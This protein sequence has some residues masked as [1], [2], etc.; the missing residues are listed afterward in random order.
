MDV[1]VICS[2]QNPS[3]KD[4]G[5]YAESQPILP[6]KWTKGNKVNKDN[7]VKQHTHL[8]YENMSFSYFWIGPGV[9]R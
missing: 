7:K 3:S 4:K 5:S 2:V 6:T 8:S 9:A 1:N